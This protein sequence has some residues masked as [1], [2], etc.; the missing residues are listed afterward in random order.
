MGAA[1]GL[2]ILIP[3]RAA[4]AACC[5]LIGLLLGACPAHFVSDYDEIFDKAISD[6]QTK[7][8]ALLQKMMDP[9]SPMRKY[10]AAKASYADIRNDIHSLKLRAQANNAGNLNEI[11]LKQLDTVDDNLAKL[12]VQHAKSPQGPSVEFVRIAQDIIDTQF[13]AILKF[14]VAKKRGETKK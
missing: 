14:E 4:L 9:Q 1:V 7:T 12:E 6:T 5:L 11:T 2:R 8:D 13:S 10:T 3:N